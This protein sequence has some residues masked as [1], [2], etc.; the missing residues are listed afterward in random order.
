M[1]TTL[2]A[3]LLT[4]LLHSTVLLLAAWGL[5]SL[6]GERRLAWADLAW[7]TALCGGLLTATLQ[8]ASGA[9]PLLGRVDLVR[10][11][12]VAAFTAA[13][14][15][16]S[17]GRAPVAQAPL[18]AP[19]SVRPPNPGTSARWSALILG[20]WGLG[21]GVCA[22]PLF[23]ASRRLAAMLRDRRAAT[24][25]PLAALRRL[26]HAGGGA[27][28]VELTV[29]PR[30][31]VPIARGVL[32]PEICLPQ[33]VAADLP[34]EQQRAVLAHELA[35]HLRRDPLWLLGGQLL[36]ALLWLQP[37]NRLA[38]RRLRAGAEILCDDWALRRN[39]GRV[40]FARCLQQVATW[41]LEAPR[42]G[43]SELPVAGM[44]SEH[45]LGHR[46]RRVLAGEQSLTLATPRLALVPCL[47]VLALV[48]STA[49]CIGSA[50]GLPSGVASE[51]LDGGA[52]R[53][54]AA[55]AARAE[56][57]A[58][59]AVAGAVQG[60]VA[61]GV[62]GGVSGGVSAAVA[63]GVEGG[64][65]GRAAVSA[66]CWYVDDAGRSYEVDCRDLPV[67]P[68]PPEPP[69]PPVPWRASAAAPVGFDGGLRREL[70]RALAAADELRAA[71]ATVGD[72]R[73]LSG[74]LDGQQ[75]KAMAELRQEL[76]RHSAER[77]ELEAEIQAEIGAEIQSQRAKVF[78]ELAAQRSQWQ[79][80]AR[81]R[82]EEMRRGLAA[83]AAAGAR[84]VTPQ[85]WP[86]PP[87]PPTPAIAPRAPVAPRAALPTVAAP[88]APWA[89][90]TPAPPP[91]PAAP[92]AALPTMPSMPPMPR[93]ASGAGLE[94]ERQLL[95]AERAKLA[96]ERAALAAAWARLNAERRSLGT[97]TP[98][99]SPS[100]APAA[101]PA[102]EGGTPPPGR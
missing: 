69:L 34:A 36:A 92:R 85:A 23:V 11:A 80:T 27:P 10:V 38:V 59:G 66:P 25:L 18:A 33:R 89:W 77:A 24:G 74:A 21:A 99:P 91:A 76:D 7:K 98:A 5:A 96:A 45:G 82:Q 71:L 53:T 17:A 26:E 31:P 57:P 73:T 60:G 3:W 14:R 43:L 88:P 9:T 87:T 1:T 79:E 62:R 52:A 54:A 101:A 46:V 86:T 63:G 47:V 6:L 32:R 2:L 56:A 55:P 51:E 102:A 50:D 61:G 16:D 49:P 90:Q 75:L 67:P 95:A 68:E 41:A 8:V 84:T 65:P 83:L 30:L 72:G 12:P 28:R 35:H 64:V 97:A 39:T 29:A 19:A 22:L 48:A 20:V 13:S 4:Y 42:P 44:A 100:P 78:A 15:L 40:A 37:L 58:E 81:Q 93:I 70:D 94:R